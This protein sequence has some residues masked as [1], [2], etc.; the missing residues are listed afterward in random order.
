VAD[1]QCRGVIRT[2]SNNGRELFYETADNRIM[3]VDY[4]VDG[5][6]FMPG[7]P[8]LWSEDSFSTPERLTWTWRGRQTVRGAIAS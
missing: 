3:V 4:A 5:A 7:K 2:L 6:S 8:R 1:L